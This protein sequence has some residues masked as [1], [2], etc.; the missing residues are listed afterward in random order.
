MS[1]EKN[2]ILDNGRLH[3]TSGPSHLAQQISEMKKQSEF[4]FPF[5]GRISIS[6][7]KNEAVKDKYVETIEHNDYEI[8]LDSFSLSSLRHRNEVWSFLIEILHSVTGLSFSFS[9]VST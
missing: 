3:P 1:D 7:L 2:N 6:S 8:K 9:M 4:Y 5:S